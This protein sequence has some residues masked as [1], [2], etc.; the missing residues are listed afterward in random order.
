MQPPVLVFGQ[1]R[2]RL[3]QDRHDALKGA[4][5]LAARGG[6]QAVR[7][8][9]AAFVLSLAACWEASKFSNWGS[10]SGMG[11]GSAG[12]GT[13]CSMVCVACLQQL[14]AWLPCLASIVYGGLQPA[15]PWPQVNVMAARA[16]GCQ[17]G[18]SSSRLPRPAPRPADTW[19]LTPPQLREH[20]VPELGKHSRH[21]AAEHAVA[22]ETFR[23][24]SC[25]LTAHLVPEPGERGRH[26][27]AEHVVPLAHLVQL[28]AQGGQ[29]LVSCCAQRV[30][31][32]LQLRLVQLLG[33]HRG[34][35]RPCARACR[36][37]RAQHVPKSWSIDP[38]KGCA[39]HGA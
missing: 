21:A 19:Q 2:P 5:V 18:L 9:W 14:A 7:A 8:S 17:A 28:L 34:L 4:P 38:Q 13:A 32:R 26:A 35:D 29:L 12:A 3:Q 37:H 6:L 15:E 31:S 25:N 27:A 10:G 1:Q 23:E 20:L 30:H 36:R 39:R 24:A 16:G 33:Y 22:A 11:L